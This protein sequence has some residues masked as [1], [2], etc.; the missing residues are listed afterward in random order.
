MLSVACGLEHTLALC[1]DG[2]RH[3]NLL[4]NLE[5]FFSPKTGI[6]SNEKTN[7]QIK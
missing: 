3:F 2:V 4:L 5:S 7:K 6:S 1:R